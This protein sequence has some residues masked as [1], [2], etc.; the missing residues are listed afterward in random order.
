MAHAGNVET[1]GR[2]ISGHHDH[3]FFSLEG[4]KR[5]GTLPLGF[6]AVHRNSRKAR[7]HEA[8]HQLLCTMLGAGK[9]KREFLA[10]LTQQLNQEFGFFS[11]RDEVNFLRHLVGGLAG[12][13]NLY[14]DR[15]G[16]VLACNFFHLL[17]HCG[18]KQ[19]GLTLRGQQRRDFAK[20]VDKAEIQHLVRFVQ[21]EELGFIQAHRLAIQQIE[22]ATGGRDQQVGTA[23]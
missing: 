12:G 22:Q 1:T 20:C 16:Q 19:H 7:V 6:V 23:L 8:F 15:V 17:G 10:V 9:H 3:G 5:A 14:A 13:R 2:H 18:R 4:L 11:L 21:H